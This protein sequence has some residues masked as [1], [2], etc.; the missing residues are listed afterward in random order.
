MN[1]PHIAFATEEI[2]A[3]LSRL[4]LSI[5]GENAREF[6]ERTLLALWDAGYACV[7]E[8]TVLPRGRVDIEATKRGKTYLIEC[9]RFSARKK[10]VLK[11]QQ[12]GRIGVV[13]CRDVWTPQ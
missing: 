9:D 4:L 1:R 6:H 2:P 12:P 5:R 11:V 7:K 10:S 3:E 8:V 13:V